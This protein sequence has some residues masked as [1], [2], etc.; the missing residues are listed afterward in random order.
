MAREVE[1]DDK[2]EAILEDLFADTKLVAR[3]VGDFGA[4]QVQGLME[5]LGLEFP[6]DLTPAEDGES[7]E[8]ED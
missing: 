3:V 4:E 8:D 7:P 2:D 6:E 5:K 1:L